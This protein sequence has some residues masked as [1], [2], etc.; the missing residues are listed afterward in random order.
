MKAQTFILAL[1]LSAGHLWSADHSSEMEALRK[2]I[3]EL[4][5]TVK[6]LQKQVERQQE[7]LKDNGVK[8]EPAGKNDFTQSGDWKNMRQDVNTALDAA[9]QKRPNTFNPSISAC[10]DTVSAYSRNTGVDFIPRG[11]E[12]MLQANV[13]Q[14]AHAYA[15]ASAHTEFDLEERTAPFRRQSHHM[16]LGLEEAAIETLSLPY[17]LKVKGGQFFADFTR[18]GKVH[19]HDRPFVDGPR[20]V[21]TIIGGETQAR[22]LE[23]SWV[24]P[25]DT[26]FRLTGGV[27]DGIGA[28]PASSNQITMPDGTSKLAWNSTDYRSFSDLMYYLRGASIFELSPTANLHAGVDYA[29]NWQSERRQLASADMKIEWKPDAAKHD[30]FTWG[31]EAL[32]SRTEGNLPVDSFNWSGA[33]YSSVAH[34]NSVG[35][36]TYV[37]Y[38][39][40][41]Y[42]EP[43]LRFDLTCPQSFEL[44]DNNGD[45]NAYELSKV[46]DRYYTY[47]AYVGFHPSEFHFLRLQASYVDVQNDVSLGGG[48]TNG[49]SCDWQVFLQWTILL[50]DH[51]HSFMP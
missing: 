22:G 9:K 36:Y 20:S 1:A 29:R 35:G 40:G 2:Q 41:K 42:W 47:S 13:D 44:R 38:R 43:G 16:H 30:L 34:A 11:M 23:L 39:F 26:Y 32:W 10:I 27:V 18:M 31:S 8:T 24:T 37:Q 4:N 46:Q 28:E 33:P 19:P 49:N 50:G 5:Q 17:G 6:T 51:R 48:N 12:L 21:D 25:L 14:Y 3:E 45:G 15:I 7:I